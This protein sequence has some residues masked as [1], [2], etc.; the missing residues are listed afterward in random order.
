MP[1]I[2]PGESKETPFLNFGRSQ[3]ASEVCLLERWTADSQ[4]SCQFHGDT[5]ILI[6]EVWSRGVG[7]G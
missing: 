7:G 3:L 2:S 1:F 6:L 4:G 5:E